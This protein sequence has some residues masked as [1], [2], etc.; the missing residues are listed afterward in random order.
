MA[1]VGN[2]NSTILFKLFEIFT[3]YKYSLNSPQVKRNMIS[4]VRNFT[5]QLL[6]EFL[7]GLRLRLQGNKEI[8]GKSQNHIGRQ[9]DA[10]H[11]VENKFPA[12]AL[13]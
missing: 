7:S 5:Y 8:L 1:F 6:H 13:Q 10:Q 3:K 4:S 2:D 9:P 11:P 12:V